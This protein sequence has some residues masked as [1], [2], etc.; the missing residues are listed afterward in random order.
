M[1]CRSCRHPFP[2]GG[3]HTES[4]GRYPRSPETRRGVREPGRAFGVRRR[5]PRAV[6]VAPRRSGEQAARA[7]GV[8][9]RDRAAVG[10]SQELHRGATLA[11]HRSRAPARRGSG[12]PEPI[13]SLAAD[14]VRQVGQLRAAGGDHH[15]QHAVSARPGHSHPRRR[16]QQQGRGAAGQRRR[17]LRHQ[18]DRLRHLVLGAGPRW[19]VRA[20]RRRQAIPGLH[21]PADDG[22]RAGTTGLAARVRRLPLRQHHERGGVLPHRHHADGALGQGHDVRAGHGLADHVGAGDRTGP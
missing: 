12:W 1:R 22:T 5:T 6:V 7:L 14:D 8:D 21:V 2:H 10:H 19:P 11:A 16:G 15:R 3:P 18:R 17:H 4:Y 20:P 13:A 9:R